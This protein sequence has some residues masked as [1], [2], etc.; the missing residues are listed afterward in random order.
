MKSRK[1]RR[2]TRTSAAVNR[3]DVVYTYVPLDDV[4]SI[5]V[6]SARCTVCKKITMHACV[7]CH[8]PF[9]ENHLTDGRCADCQEVRPS[10]LG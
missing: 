6:M 10:Y 1:K 8:K 9:C 4:K 5:A 2:K 7:E 3:R